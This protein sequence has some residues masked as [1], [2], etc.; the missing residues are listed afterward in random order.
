MKDKLKPVRCENMDAKYD[1][2]LCNPLKLL[3]WTDLWLNYLI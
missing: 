1:G 2:A 3:F